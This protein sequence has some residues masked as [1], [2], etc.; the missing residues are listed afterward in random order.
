MR[1]IDLG[2][3]IGKNRSTPTLLA[4][5][6][7]GKREPLL[8]TSSQATLGSEGRGIEVDGV[9]QS[10]ALLRVI[11]VAAKRLVGIDRDI[12]RGEGRV[13]PD[14]KSAVTTARLRLVPAA[15]K[16]ALGL[17][18]FSTVDGAT[19]EA[20]TVVLKTSVAETVTCRMSDMLCNHHFGF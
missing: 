3:V 8:F 20:N 18:K 16:R 1:I 15:G 12:F 9:R 11:G 6:G 4:V 5:L 17:V 13:L 10:A 19:A 2:C 7:T 14:G